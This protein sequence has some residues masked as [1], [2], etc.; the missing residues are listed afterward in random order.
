MELKKSQ[1]VTEVNESPVGVYIG[2]DIIEGYAK[3]RPEEMEMPPK[4]R[5]AVDAAIFMA[6]KAAV[7]KA[8][9]LSNI[10]S[11]PICENGK[12]AISIRIS[13]PKIDKPYDETTP[14]V[15]LPAEAAALARTSK[16]GDKYFIISVS[17]MWT[18]RWI[19]LP[20]G[21][22]EGL[23][24]DS[25]TASSGKTHIGDK[26]FDFGCPQPFFDKVVSLETSTTHREL[27]RYTTDHF[28]ADYKRFVNDM[29]SNVN[30]ETLSQLYNAL[31]MLPKCPAEC[32]ETQISVTLGYPE[33]FS[34]EGTETVQIEIRKEYVHD[35]EFRLADVPHE[36]LTY[37][38]TGK[39]SWA[40]QR[41][42]CSE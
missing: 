15:L 36:L 34:V 13:P 5:E 32:P 29:T 18:A 35:P 2:A 7:D 3:L 4:R 12:V 24:R 25:V 11:K 28:R 42:C 20:E 8:F 33:T 41:S 37:K 27:K 26:V 19:C 40:V 23:P 22:I 17:V 16:E 21:G 30:R 6:N 9:A 31:R 39:W 38:V 14:V 1:T 10:G